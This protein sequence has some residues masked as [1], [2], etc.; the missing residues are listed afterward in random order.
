MPTSIFKEYFKGYEILGELGRGNARVLKAKNLLTGTLVA[1][2]HF[3]FNTE[4]DTLRRFQRESEIM[5]SIEN[6]YVVKIIEVHLDAELP[7]IVMQLVEGGD[8]RSLLKINGCLDL[9][10]T[11]TMAL[12]M[13]GAL[14][15]IHTK[16]VVHRDLK[17]ENIMVRKQADGEIQFLLTDFGIAKLREQADA[18]TVTGSSMLT[19]DYASPEQFNQS[20]TVAAPTDYYSLGI[21]IYEC[22]TGVPPFEFEQDDL[23]GHINRVISSPIPMPFLPGGRSLPPAMLHLLEG[24]LRKQA[25][26]RLSDPVSVQQLLEQAA[27]QGPGAVKTKPPVPK[28]RKHYVLM[29]SVL[30][31]VIAIV[32]S[33]SN[34]SHSNGNRIVVPFDSSAE[35]SSPLVI[36][37]KQS[38]PPEGTHIVHTRQ[39]PAVTGSLAAGITN[40]GVP[41]VNGIYY[42]DFDKPDSNWATGR[43]ENSEFVLLDG[44]Y[45]MKGLKDSLSYSSS[46]KLNMDTEKDFSVAASAVYGGDADDPYQRQE[47]SGDPFGIIFCGD[48]ASDAFFVFYITSNGYYSIGTSVRDEWNA[49]QDWT[50]SSNIRPGSEMNILSIQRRGSLLSFFINGRLEKVLP[51]SNAFGSYFGL[52]IDGAQTISFDQ[53]IV[54]GSHG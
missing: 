15:A 52:R 30:L 46:I 40:P 7:Y 49:L 20:K 36:A 31:L 25:W 37:T 6:N 21:V 24:L 9:T 42:N 22:L 29:F 8:L 44:K 13:I 27:A 26:Q 3:A 54:K 43:D 16:A 32:F 34:N 14:H 1:I 19:Y 53:F 12:H 18:V 2:K 10:T 41:L 50:A 35:P 47:G 5:K 23:L 39:T 33:R 48:E 11:I 38:L 51:F 17:P 4:P 28:K 45:S